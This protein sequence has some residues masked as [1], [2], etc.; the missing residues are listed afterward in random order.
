MKKNKMFFSIIPRRPSYASH[1]RVIEYSSDKVP[2]EIQRFL[3]EYKN[4]VTED[5]P[6]SLPS[7]RSISHYMDIIPGAILPNKAPYRLTPSENE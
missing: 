3:D 1:N 5:I 7:A 6:N 2:I 4:I